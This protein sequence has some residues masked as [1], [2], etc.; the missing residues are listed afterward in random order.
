MSTA[1]VQ[2]TC[3]HDHRGRHILRTVA[4]SAYRGCT[5]IDVP[6]ADPTRTSDY[7]AERAIYWLDR[8]TDHGAL[9]TAQVHATLA[10]AFAIK[11][12]NK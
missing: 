4:D 5:F 6:A 8:A 2:M 1:M 7:H 3:D 9:A 12:G 11:E 10:V